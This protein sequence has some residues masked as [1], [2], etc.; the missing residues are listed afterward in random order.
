MKFVMAGGGTGGHVIPALA[1]AQELRSRGHQPVFFGTRQ[2][3]EGRL[4]P[5]AGLPIEW[6]EVGG[7]NRVS[8]SQKLRALLLLPRSVLQ[9]W[10][11]IR[12]EHP[13]AVF[14]MGGYVAG[15]VVIAAILRD[16]PIV[17]MEPNAVPGMTN[18]KAARW[19]ARALVNFEETAAWF[20]PGRT[21]VTGVPVRQEFFRIAA[22]KPGET[23]TLLVTGGSQGSRTLNQAGR[24]SWPLFAKSGVPIRIVHQAGR[25][26]A[27]PL[28]EA[29][30]RT[31]LPGEVVEFIAD[32]PAAF[33]Q[34]DLVV[35]RAGAST[36]SELAAAG[37]ASLLVPF[38]Y[39]A[40]DHQQRNAE[41]MARAGAARVV[42][43]SEMSGRRM[44][45][46]VIALY[47]ARD[48]LAAMARNAREMAKPRAAERA[49]DVLEQIAVR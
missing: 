12:R 20:P 26:N 34:A 31:E 2:G 44:F 49:A 23:F 18:R 15:P 7:L 3:Y 38:P 17:A 33:A 46:E 9:V 4:V 48:R 36:V 6:I 5:A 39:A 13:G 27:A 24:D 42:P 25:G 19:T 21:E 30:A 43:D 32:M 29:F 1:V 41:A 11:W 40:D 37:R 16:V 47:S 10:Q 35:C 28:A 14:S 22:R 8:L 45:D